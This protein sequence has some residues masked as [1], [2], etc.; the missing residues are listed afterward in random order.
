MKIT[1]WEKIKTSTSIILALSAIVSIIFSFIN[2]SIQKNIA[3]SQWDNFTKLNR[4][5]ICITSCGIVPYDQTKKL[6]RVHFKIK[7][8]GNL[9]AYKVRL[10]SIFSADSSFVFDNSQQKERATQ[11]VN[12][13]KNTESKLHSSQSDAT[14][15][16]ENIIVD[17]NISK[18][19]GPWSSLYPQQERDTFFGK[20]IGF[21]AIQN[22]VRKYRYF[23][24]QITYEDVDGN[25]NLYNSCSLCYPHNLVFVNISDS[26]TT[27]VSQR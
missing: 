1:I 20:P 22:F 11:P 8:V 18:D 7:N 10:K 23:H 4:P 6:F 2:I 26:D 9:P 25:L 21:N 17:Y 27:Q 19:Q 3:S 12:N 24:I 16:R 15:F 14:T 13:I 5:Y